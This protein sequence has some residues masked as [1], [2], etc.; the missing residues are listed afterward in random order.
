[1]LVILQNMN[2]SV[3]IAPRIER[4]FRDSSAHAHHD[5]KDI[6]V[7]NPSAQQEQQSAPCH[8]LTLHQPHIPI[9][10]L[11]GKYILTKQPCTSSDMLNES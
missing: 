3:C 1:M 9:P 8:Q 5:H 10:S 6:R 2:R 7:F 4:I 11:K